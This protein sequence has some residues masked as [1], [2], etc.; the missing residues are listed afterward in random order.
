VHALLIVNPHAT[1]T[2]RQRR[3]VI[4]RALASAIDL[5]VV[6]TRYRGEATR[7]AATAA[8][9]GFDVVMTLGG[10]GT[11]NEAVNGLLGGAARDFGTTFESGT[12][13]DSGGTSG[14]GDVE[15]A[16]GRAEGAHGAD[17]GPP[18]AAEDLP[19]LAALPGG[20]ANVFTR[21]LGL[22]ADP[23]DAA[24]RLIDDLANGRERRIGLGA[25]N[26]RYFTFN[27]GLG[28]DA[29]VVR[30]VEGRRAAGR[31]LTPTLFARTALRQYYQVTNRRHAAIRLTEPPKL[32]PD[33]V[34]VCLVSNS[35]P[36]TYLGRR[37]VNTNP[38]ASFDT[39]LDLLAL[40]RLG[41]VATLRTLRQMLASRT[42]S[43]TGRSVLSAHDLSAIEL[44]ADHPLAFQLDGEYMGEVEQV[45]FRSVPK[46]LRVIG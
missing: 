27:A 3:D 16:T 11:V 25:A 44:W 33:P 13:F 38:G 2:T 40:R 4:V 34:F 14:P 22:P 41:T 12:T 46:A 7:L 36:W 8:S 5:E 17:L 15:L 19:A 28:L 43:P 10:D 24:G 45:S 18:P 1:S 30:A 35:A 39:G 26:G 9:A 21:S 6:E 29:E 23:V 20:N 37:A 31:A 42:E 32:C